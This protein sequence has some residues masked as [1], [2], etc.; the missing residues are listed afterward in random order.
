[1]VEL[2]YSVT[3][4][5]QK[6]IFVYGRKERFHVLGDVMKGREF[7]SLLAAGMFPFISQF[8]LGLKS[9]RACV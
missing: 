8:E 9:A 6:T 2:D 3:A 5:A 1:V 7:T 4:H